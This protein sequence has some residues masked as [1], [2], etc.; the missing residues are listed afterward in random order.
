[1]HKPLV[2]VIA[3][4]LITT[5]VVTV[6]QEKV[7]ATDAA[8][9]MEVVQQASI[10][11]GPF[12]VF[13]LAGGI[14]VVGG[15]VIYDAY[16]INDGIIQFSKIP[17][18]PDKYEPNSTLEKVHPKTGQ[19]IQRRYYD[20]SGRPRLDVDLTNHGTPQYHPWEQHKHRWVNGKRLPGEPLT[21]YEK[22]KYVHIPNNMPNKV[23]GD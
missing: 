5:T 16:T 17:R 14:I 6:P 3:V 18:L 22:V 8:A 11:A 23:K 2:K 20:E 7:Y 21:E 12:A 4:C 15:V 9:T 1:M 13:V 19:V 10:S